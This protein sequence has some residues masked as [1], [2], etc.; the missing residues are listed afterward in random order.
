M[1]TISAGDD[2]LSVPSI[3]VAAIDEQ[4]RELFAICRAMARSGAGFRTPLLELEAYAGTHFVAE[5]GLMLMMDYPD[6]QDHKSRH[7]A[8]LVELHACKEAVLRDEDIGAAL[9]GFV[10]R[11]L[12]EHVVTVDGTLGDFLRDRA[13]AVAAVAGAGEEVDIVQS[14]IARNREVGRSRL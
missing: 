5:E 10:S 13:G 2:E 6:F 1:K 11:W 14:V 7:D 12:R 3:G 8:F 4:H 9:A